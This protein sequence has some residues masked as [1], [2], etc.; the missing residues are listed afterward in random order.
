MNKKDSRLRRS[1]CMIDARKNRYSLCSDFGLKPVH[2]VLGP[3]VTE[4]RRQS[5][6]VVPRHGADTAECCAATSSI[7]L[8]GSLGIR[9][10]LFVFSCR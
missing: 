6:H 3:E 9:M 10:P 5:F 8:T 2:G 7:F 1:R 4:Y